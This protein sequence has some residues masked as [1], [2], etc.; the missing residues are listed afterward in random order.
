M[1]RRDL[2]AHARRDWESH[3]CGDAEPGHGNLHKQRL[4]DVRHVAH[5]ADAHRI[6][7]DGR[8]KANWV[9]DNSRLGR[10]H[11]PVSW[12]SANQWFHRSIYGHVEFIFDWQTITAGRKLYWVETIPY[13][14]PAYRI[15]VTDRQPPRRL[16]VRYKPRKHRG[17][18]VRRGETWFWNGDHRVSEFMLQDDLPLEQCKAINF[19][20]HRHDRC[21]VHSPNCP[22]AAL[23]PMLAKFLTIGFVLASSTHSAD[24]ILRREHGWLSPLDQ[25]VNESLPHLSLETRFRRPPAKPQNARSLMRAI[26]ALWSYR[27]PHGA[28]ALARR[29]SKKAFR[30]TL[31]AVVRD[32]FDQPDYY[33]KRS[34]NFASKL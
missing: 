23:N 31:I 21:K 16:V 9:R 2:T 27:D 18:L 10:S 6:L 12:L 13:E 20:K 7:A 25:F 24:T 34:R 33:P 28:Y 22:D 5:L 11:R 32:H 30:K 4:T 19:V 1:D 17:P 26:L 29:F 15:L 14:T 3:D 8:I